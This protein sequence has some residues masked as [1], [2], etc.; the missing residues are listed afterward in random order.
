MR[1]QACP[2]QSFCSPQAFIAGWTAQQHALRC[3]IKI[4]VHGDDAQA[5]G[6][7]RFW[8]G[9]HRSCRD[10]CGY[11]AERSTR[12][13]Q[14]L[15]AHQREERLLEATG[16]L[17]LQAPAHGTLLILLRLLHEL[18]HAW[19]RF[20]LQGLQDR[21]RRDKGQPGPE[22]LVLLEAEL[23]GDHRRHPSQVLQSIL[24]PR[25]RQAV[26]GRQSMA[27]PADIGRSCRRPRSLL[28]CHVDPGVLPRL[29]QP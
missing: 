29:R 20:G 23:V 17:L 5:T 4:S 12:M 25:G 11:Q 13:R 19:P 15:L 24:L 28:C 14:Q 8:A 1:G 10:L 26:E 22:L 18:G 21:A 16:H 3:N 7:H 2:A 6:Q 27:Q 9:G